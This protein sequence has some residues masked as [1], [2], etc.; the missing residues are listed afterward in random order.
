MRIT[1]EKIAEINRINEAAGSNRLKV[2]CSL[3]GSAIY[4][5]NWQICKVTE[6]SKMI[7]ELIKMRDVIE[8]E[9][10]IRF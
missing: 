3:G 1:E 6:L 2:Y 4:D 9:T 10:G 5:G 7:D 8:N